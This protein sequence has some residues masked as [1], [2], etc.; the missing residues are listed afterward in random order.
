[1]RAVIN[2][3]NRAEAG[4]ILLYA[5]LRAAA[6]FIPLTARAPARMVR[7]RGL[8]LAALDPWLRNLLDANSRSAR[9]ADGCDKAFIRA[10]HKILAAMPDVRQAKAVNTALRNFE[11]SKCVERMASYPNRMYMELT[12][13]CNMKCPMCTQ[14]TMSGRRTFMPMEIVEKARPVM[15]YMDLIHFVGCG[16]TFLH[17]MFRE[18][19]RAAPSRTATLR[20]ITNG[21]LL[22]QD[23]SRFVVEQQLA[24]LWVSLDA[25]TART[26]AIIRESDQFGN[27]LDNLRLL[28]RIKRE[29][30]SE[31]PNVALNFVARRCNIDELPEFIR[32]AT[33]LG[34]GAVNV[35]YLQVYRRELVDES[36]FYH[37]ELSDRM[38]RQAEVVA[39]EAGISLY[40][41][42]F[43]SDRPEIA[44]ASSRAAGKCAE[45]YHFVYVRA[46]GTLGPCCVNDARLGSLAEQSFDE[47]WNGTAYQ[48][49][50]RVVNTAEED[51]HC[52]HCMLEGYKDIHEV[53]HHLKFVDQQ[54]RVEDIDYKSIAGTA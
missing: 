17:P 32:M 46:E 6:I 52:R 3:L 11:H 5:G 7:W 27:I 12:N 14:S 54:Q 21:L 36:L 42:G 47:L 29:A 15:R 25:A 10:S 51:L 50:R 1:M 35:G 8:F 44:P 26:F 20:I 24:E 38:M 28:R 33:D 41:P 2:R 16:E 53:E 18:I 45:P 4:R 19:L 49:F 37:Q 48:R 9:M 13:A 43:F 23:M 30:G 22:D 39:R 31:H 40:L 34:A